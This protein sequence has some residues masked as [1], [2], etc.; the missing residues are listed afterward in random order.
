MTTC[1]TL[2]EFKIGLRSQAGTTLIRLGRGEQPLWLHVQTAPI[3]TRDVYAHGHN[4]EIF[5]S[6][7]YRY[8]E[9]EWHSPARDLAPGDTMSFEQTFKVSTP[10]SLASGATTT[11][12][13]MELSRCMS[14]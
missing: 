4:V 12:A 2:H 14:S 3:T 1:D 6:K 7:D 8:S 10:E 5:S 11:L 13:E 9:A